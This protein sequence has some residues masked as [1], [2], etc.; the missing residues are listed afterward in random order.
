MGLGLTT[1]SHRATAIDT[2]SCMAIRG[3]ESSR[4]CEQAGHAA[5]AMRS[6]PNAALRAM[7]RELLSIPT[8]HNFDELWAEAGHAVA[9][10]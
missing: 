10:P 7:T 3:S 8:H 4:I 5:T 9:Y 6:H 2:S 1:T